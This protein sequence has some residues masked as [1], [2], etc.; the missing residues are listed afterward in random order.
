MTAGGFVRSLSL[1]LIAAF[2]AAAESRGGVPPR[3]SILEE[4]GVGDAFFVPLLEKV[5]GSRARWLRKA[6]ECRP[7]LRH[8]AVRAKRV[9]RIGADASAFQ[10]WAVH[11]AG[12]VADMLNRP[13]SQGDEFIVDFGEHI[14]GRFALK[15]VD[16]GKA[17]DAPVRLALSFAEMPCELVEDQETSNPSLSR[18]WYQSEV[19]TFDDVPCEST[20]PRRYAFRYV[21]LKV[22]GCSSGGRFGLG[23]IAATAETSADETC[24]KAWEPPSDAA[25]KIDAVACRTLRDCMQTVFEDGPK[26]DRRLWLGDL[27]LEALANYETYRNFEVVKRSLYLLAGTCGEGGLV[28]SDAYERPVSRSGSCRILDYT[29]IFAATVLEYLEASGDE[30]TAR[31]LWPLCAMQTKFALNCVCRDG[32]FRDNGKWWCFID[33][34]KPLNRQTAEQGAIIYGLRRTWELA[35][36]LGRTSDVRF[37]PDVVAKMEHGARSALWSESKGCFVCE[38]DAQVSW[39]GQ[40]WLVLAGV[41]DVT[42]ARRCLKTA[43]EDA[44]AVRPVTPY[45]HHYFIEAL[46]AAGM[47]NEGDARLLSYFGGMAE[48]GADT[49]WEVFVPENH[50]AGPYK[51][52]LMNSYCHAWS[53]GPS[54]FLRNAKYKALSRAGLRREGSRP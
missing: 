25:A 48:L 42:S 52:H 17:V 28:N 39:M 31:D 23:R 16:F 29:A 4:H 38:K 27:R 41:P 53:C 30:E 20:L 45:A 47:K 46:Y 3:G 10:G 11:D 35:R 49:F 15:L 34:Q 2:V 6:E 40:A 14:V 26:R 19:V 7:A 8:R 24:L 21:R 32:V 12:A 9:V 44:D 5:R 54:Y 33:W 13:L 1:A 37:V 51:T 18:S 36:R 22:V 50:R 43:M